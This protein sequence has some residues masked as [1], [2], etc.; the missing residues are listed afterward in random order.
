MTR[1]TNV[2]SANEIAQIQGTVQSD[3]L[4][5]KAVLQTVFE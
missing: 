1:R 2:L 5:F 3:V 4:D